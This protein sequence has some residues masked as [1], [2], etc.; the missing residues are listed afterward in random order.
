MAINRF[1][2]SIHCIITSPSGFSLFAQDNDFKLLRPGDAIFQTFSGETVKYEGEELY[3]FFVNECA[4]YEKKVAF[5]LAKKITST[6]PSIS[7]KK[8]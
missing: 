6:C 1:C 7:V 2:I 8:E 4:Y 5:I 3:P